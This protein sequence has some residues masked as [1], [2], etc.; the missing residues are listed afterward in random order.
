MAKFVHIGLSLDPQIEVTLRCDEFAVGDNDEIQVF[1][2]DELWGHFP[3][4]IYAYIEDDEEDAEPRAK[5]SDEE[6]EDDEV[7]MPTYESVNLS[8]PSTNGSGPVEAVDSKLL[9]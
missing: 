1:V 9:N 7:D 5:V 8:P 4:S 3:E 6:D 2:G